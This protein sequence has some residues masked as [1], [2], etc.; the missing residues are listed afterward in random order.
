[1]RKWI[2]TVYGFCITTAVFVAWIG[3]S[4]AYEILAIDPRLTTAAVD[5]RLLRACTLFTGCALL[6]GIAA[7]LFPELLR[8]RP[9]ALACSMARATGLLLLCLAVVA[10][11][12]GQGSLVYAGFA[13]SALT[14]FPAL[15]VVAALAGF[16]APFAPA[17]RAHRSRIWLVASSAAWLYLLL[18]WFVARYVAEATHSVASEVFAAAVLVGFVACAAV[19]LKSG[20]VHE[21]VES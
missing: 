15:A 9:G 18:Y 16:L 12:G 4:N 1:V 17:P 2:P 5:S 10:I 21:T 19:W 8:R 11:A 7:H 3:A 13:S 6:G 14:Q 20:L